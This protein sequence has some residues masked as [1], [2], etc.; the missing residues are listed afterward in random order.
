MSPGL[1]IYNVA[2]DVPVSSP[3]IDTGPKSPGS[4]ILTFSTPAFVDQIYP[5]G[6]FVTDTGLLLDNV[7]VTFEAFALPEPSNLILVIFGL[8]PLALAVRS[9]SARRLR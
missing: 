2:S 5:P 9:S 3:F 7:I 8:I 4:F 6:I 1:I